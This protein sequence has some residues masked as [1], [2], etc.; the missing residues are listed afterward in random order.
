LSDLWKKIGR[1]DAKIE[2]DW[3]PDDPLDPAATGENTQNTATFGPSLQPVKNGHSITMSRSQ[4]SRP[5]DDSRRC[6]QDQHQQ[7]RH[8]GWPPIVQISAIYWNNSAKSDNFLK[9]KKCAANLLDERVISSASS[10][11][12]V[13]GW[14][15]WGG[16][17]DNGPIRK[18]LG[19][20]TSP[21]K[22]QDKCAA[23]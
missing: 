1:L 2:N 4:L 19:L 9:N 22:Q 12:L 14:V 20:M 16:G 11:Q 5:I 6:P 15:G 8:F 13:S 17:Y 7:S 23:A 18:S 21:S 10:G 3:W